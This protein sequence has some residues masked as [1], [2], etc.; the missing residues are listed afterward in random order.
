M[1]QFRRTSY[2]KMISNSNFGDVKNYDL[3]I[4]SSI[5][6][7]NTAKII[8]YFINNNEKPH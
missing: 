3:C 4:D 5:G 7:Q 6:V 1:E 8:C 2:Y